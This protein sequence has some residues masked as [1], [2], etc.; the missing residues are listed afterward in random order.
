M[1]IDVDWSH[2][3]HMVKCPVCHVLHCACQCPRDRWRYDI[4]VRRAADGLMYWDASEHAWCKVI[5]SKHESDW[6]QHI[7]R[8]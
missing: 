6:R 8:N 2:R 3:H 4:V 7:E 1:P 5:G